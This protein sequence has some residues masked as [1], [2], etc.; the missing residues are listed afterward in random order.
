MHVGARGARPPGPVTSLMAD[1]R[2]LWRASLVRFDASPVIS[3]VDGTST[4]Q[5]A[6][7]PSWIEP[8]AGTSGRAGLL[9]RSQNCSATVGGECVGCAGTGA[10]ASVMSFAL[11]EKNASGT[12]PP[13]FKRIDAS[14]V[15]FGPHDAT[16]DEG[17]EDPR[18]VYD[19]ESGRYYMFYTCFNSGKAK[20]QAAI[21]LCLASNADPT[22]VPWNVG[23]VRHGPVG[24][25]AGSKSG[26]LL[27]GSVAEARPHYLLW[28]AG[29]IRVTNS[30]DL[31]RWPSPGSVLLT[32]TLWGNPHVEAGP[33]PLR[34]STGD[35]LFFF[36]SWRDD[37]PKPPGYEPAWAILDGADPTHIVAQASAPLFEPA[38]ASWCRGV[39]PYTCNVANVAFVEAAHHASEAEAA[40]AGA[41]AGQDLVRIYF[42][43]ADAVVGSALVQVSRTSWV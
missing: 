43:G 31:T 39:A 30:S 11:L 37:F 14:S 35:W 6:F 13:Q 19:T 10:K 3:F 7:N 24:F 29:T 8:S 12:H 21:P 1:S 18:V 4:Y 17:T 9:V 25:G 33:P 34:L 32:R 16:D 41:K 5:Q 2:H 23:W 15:S 42:G 38:R 36:N 27:V 22:H 28:G 20:P 26:A 40:A